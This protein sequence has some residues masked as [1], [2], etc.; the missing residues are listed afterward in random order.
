MSLGVT[1]DEDYSIRRAFGL[2]KTP[3]RFKRTVFGGTLECD[4]HRILEVRFNR[5]D[6][7]RVEEIKQSSD[8]G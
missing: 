2:S 3:L 5:G 6:Q 7:E 4:R 8:T 1:L